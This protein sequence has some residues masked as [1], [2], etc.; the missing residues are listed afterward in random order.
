MV[1]V[2]SD[3]K[4]TDSVEFKNNE[5]SP[6]EFWDEVEIKEMTFLPYNKYVYY[7]I[8][9]KNTSKYYHGILDIKLNKIMFNT[10]EQIDV[11]IPYSQN[12]MLAITNESAYKICAIPSGDSC[13]ESCSTGD[14]Y[15]DLDGNRCGTSC[16][17]ENDYILIPE[18]V[19]ISDCDTSIFIKNDTHCGLCRDM[20]SDKKYKLINGTECLSSI[21]EG[22]DIYNENLGLLVC[23][24]GY[25]F[26][27]DNGTCIPH[28]YNTCE[29]CTEYSTSE[30][31]QHCINCT[32][33]YYLENGYD[34]N[35]L[36]IVVYAECTG[37]NQIKCSLCNE[38]SNE[39]QLCVDCKD[40]YEKVNYTT[41]Y[42]EFFDCLKEDNPILKRFYYDETA[43]EYK[44]CYKT[45]KRC[46]IGG[47]AEANNCL[48]CISGY[49]LRPGDNPKN[50]CIAYSEYYFTTSYNQI[51]SLSVFQ[52]PEEAKYMIKDRKSCIDDCQ[53][54]DEY[55][56]LYN[57]N[58]VKE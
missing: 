32:D 29:I 57:G 49:M 36:K 54:D 37:E 8:Y 26:N 27:N 45:C 50:N 46:L 33:G 35:C 2:G 17:N 21:P 19:C 52:C 3:Y 31:A 10:D 12:A 56:Y 51:K 9:N 13:I 25:I 18:E 1:T 40:G 39:L 41:L 6:F 58:C 53:K 23:K 30:T 38:R 42:P 15:L 34:S 47:D 4:I 14:L 24:S 48:E 22:Y 7:S 5:K 44:P 28:C 20:Y 11:F 16:S 55:K 43:Q